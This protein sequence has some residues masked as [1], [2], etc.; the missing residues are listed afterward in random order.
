[1]ITR[2]RAPPVVQAADHGPG[3]LRIVLHPT[4]GEVLAYQRTATP[5]YGQTVALLP[6]EQYVLCQT[7]GRIPG[8]RSHSGTD[9][10]VGGT[11]DHRPARACERP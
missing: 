10:V 5:R 8:C 4:T 1:V 3:G 2:L 9:L 11:G 6:M 7:R